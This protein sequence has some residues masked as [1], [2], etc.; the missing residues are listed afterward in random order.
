MRIS[1]AESR[2]RQG[3]KRTV[4]F[5]LVN[6]KVVQRISKNNRVT[7]D[8]S[9]NKE[10]WGD[11]ADAM[12]D[13]QQEIMNQSSQKGLPFNPEK[14]KG[15]PQSKAQLLDEL[16]DGLDAR[17]LEELKHSDIDLRNE[18]KLRDIVDTPNDRD[19][20]K[21]KEDVL[22]LIYEEYGFNWFTM[23]QFREVYDVN[24]NKSEAYRWLQR[25]D[26]RYLVKQEIPEDERE[27]NVKYRYKLGGNA[28][29]IIENYGAFD[30]MD[31]PVY[32]KKSREY[33][34]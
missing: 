5:H 1:G 18:E 10:M 28:K 19:V 15:G 9:Y 32:K 20:E 24:Y 31:Y 25:L 6:G 17:E 29:R 11:I 16:I 23:P 21:I 14:L 30:T 34:S 12:V 8:I 33:K 22:Q 13:T 4:E 3:N 2:D 26:D 7:H 27:G